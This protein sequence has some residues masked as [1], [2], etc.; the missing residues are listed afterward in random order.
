MVAVGVS[1]KASAINKCV[2]AGGK[3]AY[4]DQPCTGAAAAS[5]IDVGAATATSSSGQ[6]P[7]VAIAPG[8]K[9]LQACEEKRPG[10]CFQKE[11]LEKKCR[12]PG[13]QHFKNSLAECRTYQADHKKFDS[14]QGDCQSGRLPAACN[15]L[16]CAGGDNMACERM[17]TA[18][19]GQQRREDERVETTRQKG[20]PSGSGW[21]MS[22]DW[23]KY[24]DG[25]LAATINCSAKS[26]VMLIRKPPILER[27]FTSMTK[28]QHF[29]TVEEAAK[30]ACA[31]TKH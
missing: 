1:S 15:T 10:P 8:L 30:T 27:I 14:L 16:A 22:Q 19:S 11:M 23:S 18:D 7:A 3:I 25:R 28:D 4:S 12:V 9:I 21:Y 5:K 31:A 17:K 13:T 20:L 29:V 2:D 24:P 6:S 26:S